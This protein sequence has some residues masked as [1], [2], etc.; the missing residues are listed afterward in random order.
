MVEIECPH[1]DED[2]ELD[3]G[4]YGSFD[5]PLCGEEFEW[6]S[7]SIWT[8]D[9]F[10]KWG[11]RSGLAVFL[12]GIVSAILLWTTEGIRNCKPASGYLYKI[13]EPLEC[14]GGLVVFILG[15]FFAVCILILPAIVHLLRKINAKIKQL[16]SQGQ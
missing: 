8:A 12:F 10:V 13:P 9:N 14:G 4:V 7:P 3:D 15:G 1:C 6:D 16:T 2:I 5:C 11:Y